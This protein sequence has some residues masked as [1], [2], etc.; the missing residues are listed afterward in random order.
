LELFNSTS[1]SRYYLLYADRKSSNDKS[2]TQKI[3]SMQG[4]RFSL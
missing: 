3:I 4:L 1:D 2:A